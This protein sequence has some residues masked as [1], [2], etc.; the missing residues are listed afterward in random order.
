[1]LEEEDGGRLVLV[2]PALLPIE[3]AGEPEEAAGGGL[4]GDLVEEVAPGP[5][6]AAEDGVEQGHDGDHGREGHDPEEAEVEG[7]GDDADE[8]VGPLDGLG[9][10]RLRQL[11]GGQPEH[12]RLQGVDLR[13]QWGGGR[14]AGGEL[15]LGPLPQRF[16]LVVGWLGVVKVKGSIG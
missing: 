3:D 10:G 15:V 2:A 1:M 12:G 9:Q 4:L 6:E 7:A 14:G 16:G 5:A 13:E 11:R 8:A